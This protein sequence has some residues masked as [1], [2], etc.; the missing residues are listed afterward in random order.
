MENVDKLIRAISGNDKKIAHF[1]E[2]SDEKAY[3]MFALGAAVFLSSIL[4]IGA[5]GITGSVAVATYFSSGTLA[6]L[7]PLA[8]V[9]CNRYLNRK[10]PDQDSGIL[11]Q[12]RTLALDLKEDLRTI[13]EL[14]LPQKE[15]N[16]LKREAY[17]EYKL[18]RSQL[19]LLRIT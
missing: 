2:M 5:L 13:N 14:K 15:T 12:I 1:L 4:S 18:K 9:C 17:K 19:E 7:G 11:S 6:M 16:Q 3:R 8:I 10:R